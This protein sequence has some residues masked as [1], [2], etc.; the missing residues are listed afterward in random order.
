MF[1]Y[2]IFKAP[3]CGL[4]ALLRTTTIYIYIYILQNKFAPCSCES[5]MLL[6]SHPYTDISPSPPLPVSRLHSPVASM[7]LSLR[8]LHYL[9]RRSFYGSH[10]S[11]IP[12]WC[13]PSPTVRLV[14]LARPC[15]LAHP[16][17]SELARRIILPHLFI[18]CV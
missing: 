6:G 17:T 16:R 15:A 14:T 7:Y 2:R 1:V 13:L 8:F 9:Y 3:I 4:T 11:P 5:H 10:I 12:V 18:L